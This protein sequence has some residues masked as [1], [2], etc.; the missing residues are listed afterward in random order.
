M[1]KVILKTALKTLLAVAFAAL[2]AFGIASLGF[3]SEMATLCEGTGN[4]SMATGYSSLA[5]A[6]SNK[7]EDLNR[8]F[9]NGLHAKNDGSIIKYGDKLVKDE[10][11]KEICEANSKT[12]PTPNGGEVKIDYKQYVYGNLACAKYRQKDKDGAFSC[13]D[14]GM[15]GLDGFP[16]NN[17]LAV[18]SLQVI[19]SGD[20]ETAKLLLEKIN[21]FTPKAAEEAYFNALKTEL[22]KAGGEK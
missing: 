3:P 12:V 18:L 11:F 16:V 17:A 19:E 7:A 8:C 6:Y 21:K 9:A 13:A 15:N 20:G 10:R 5:Y 22:E 2:V 14:E 1:L 4:Y